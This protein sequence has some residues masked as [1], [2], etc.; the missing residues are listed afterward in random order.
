MNLKIYQIS[1]SVSSSGRK[2]AATKR[3]IRWRFGF[4]NEEAI[5]NG[6]SGV[7][8]RGS[9]HEVTL[10]W[11]LASGKRIVLQDG[12]EVHYSVGRR[13]ESKF[14]STWVMKGENILKIVAH[15][16]LPLRNKENWKQYDLIFNGQSFSDLLHVYQL[17]L[18]SP[19]GSVNVNRNNSPPA[20]KDYKNESKSL[21]NWSPSGL[22]DEGPSVGSGT[23]ATTKCST[24]SGN[25]SVHKSK[26]V[27]V[28]ED[29]DVLT[30][31]LSVTHEQSQVKLD[32][33]EASENR[34]SSENPWAS[35]MNAYHDGSKTCSAMVQQGEHLG[36]G[37][38]FRLESLEFPQGYKS[39]SEEKVSFEEDQ[40]QDNHTLESLTSATVADEALAALVNLDI[41]SPSKKAR[42]VEAKHLNVTKSSIDQSLSLQE[43]Q[44]RKD[45]MKQ[46]KQVLNSYLD[47][48][49]QNK[50]DRPANCGAL[51]VY[52]RP[53]C[54]YLNQ[55]P[56]PL[57]KVSGFGVGSVNY[58]DPLDYKHYNIQRLH[59]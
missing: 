14:E 6:C 41:M 45:S 57:T 18:G 59:F 21:I 2:V 3:R 5:R 39:T 13:I 20:R 19:Y 54:N 9:E 56:P 43:L 40:K 22:S 36:Q 10:V 50:T 35:I 34:L 42:D 24:L 46:P 44:N 48:P 47:T 53:Q 37:N 4:I 1:C 7:D 15:A 51:V 30:S 55:G 26:F 28:R 49:I 33:F 38:E 23:T 32:V 27:E 25:V 17:G 58:I 31:P 29:I 8:C 11:S 12:D 52:D 16:G